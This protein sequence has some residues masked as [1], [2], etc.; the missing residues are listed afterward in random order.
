MNFIYTCIDFYS[1]HVVGYLYEE[2]D[3]N[4]YERVIKLENVKIKRSIGR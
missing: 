2:E 1:R 4:E 3:N